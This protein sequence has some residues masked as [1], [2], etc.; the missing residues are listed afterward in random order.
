[1]GERNRL[2]AV[3]F[4]STVSGGGYTGSFLGRLFTQPT[5]AKADDRRRRGGVGGHGG[6]M[7]GTNA[8]CGMRNAE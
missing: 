4:L 8:E 1:M 3:D 6:I 2:R 7:R 5:A